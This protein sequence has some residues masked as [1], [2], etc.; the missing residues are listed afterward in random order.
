M[1]LDKLKSDIIAARLSVSSLE[2][3]LL[4]EESFSLAVSASGCAAQG[5]CQSYCAQGCA[6]FGTS[7]CSNSCTHFLAF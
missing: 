3:A 2:E 7:T 4:F 5:A 6:S 1:Q